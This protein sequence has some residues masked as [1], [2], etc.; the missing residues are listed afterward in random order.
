MQIPME[1]CIQLWH[2]VMFYLDYS[3][4]EWDLHFENW[5]EVD[6]KDFL[7]FQKH[8]LSPSDSFPPDEITEFPLLSVL[9]KELAKEGNLIVAEPTPMSS[10][11][12]TAIVEI[13]RPQGEPGRVYQPVVNEFVPVQKTTS[14]LDFYPLE[15]TDLDSLDLFL[16]YRHGL[17]KIEEVA[18]SVK[19][20]FISHFE[21]LESILKAQKENQVLQVFILIFLVFWTC[22]FAH[23]NGE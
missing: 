14:S 19:P 12:T 5:E 16:D 20:L 6:N 2:F 4:S 18:Q 22:Y 17:D 10:E 15:T 7:L 23:E 13:H 11:T 1:K 9:A 21:K 8:K 3:L